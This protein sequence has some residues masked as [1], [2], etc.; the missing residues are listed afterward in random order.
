MPQCIPAY[1]YAQYDGTNGQAVVDAINAHEISSI[2]W[3]FVSDT[4]TVLTCNMISD[5]AYP[6]EFT[7]GQVAVFEA[8]G[9]SWSGAIIDPAVFAARY[10]VV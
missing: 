7:V 1:E 4:G 2:T 6:Y 5:A 9:R 10:N 3:E 8:N